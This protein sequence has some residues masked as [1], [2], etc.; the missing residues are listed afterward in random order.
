MAES[1]EELAPTK[2]LVRACNGDYWL[3][4]EGAIPEKVHS[5][6][7]NLQPQ[8]PELVNFITTTN[9]N[10]ATLFDEA[11]PGVKVGI[12]VVDFDDQY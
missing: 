8:K 2:I 6:D 10:L 11:N 7:P 4:R 1:E 3:I 5:N 12:T 9:G